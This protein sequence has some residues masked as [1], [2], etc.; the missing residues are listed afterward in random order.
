[1]QAADRGFAGVLTMTFPM[2]RQFQ[3]ERDRAYQGFAELAGR[4]QSAGKLR[5]DFV[6]ED[7]VVLLMANAGVVAW[8]RRCCPRDLAAL[9]RLHDQG[10]QRRQRRAATRA[11][12]TRRH[13]PGPAAPPPTRPG[14]RCGY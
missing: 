5:A 6:P 14:G 9:R 11:T 8:H 4:A 13:L 1:M 10:L 7:L 2:A 3:A 12:R